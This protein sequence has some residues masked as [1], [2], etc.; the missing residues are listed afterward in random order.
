MRSVTLKPRL[1]GTRSS[2]PSIDCAMRAYYTDVSATEGAK[3]FVQGSREID[4][5]AGAGGDPISNSIS[6]AT[7]VHGVHVDES[8]KDVKTFQLDLVNKCLLEH[9]YHRF[10]LTDAQRK[11]LE[12]LKIGS[13]ERH[14]YLYHLASDPA[15]LTAQATPDPTPMPQP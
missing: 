2:G 12:K 10:Q 4:T 6:V 11:Q 1:G 8:L 15:V 7:V 14:N 5:I 13:E 3:N 9:G